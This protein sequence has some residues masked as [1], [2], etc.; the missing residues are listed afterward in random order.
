MRGPRKR[1]PG[2]RL[3]V[4]SLLVPAA[5]AVAPAALAT[6]KGQQVAG[7]AST[8][9]S[10]TLHSSPHD[11]FGRCMQVGATLSHVPAVGETADLDITLTATEPRDATVR[12]LLPAS[13]ALASPR[14]LTRAATPASDG[15]VASAFTTTRDLAAHSTQHLH[16]ALRGI[17]AGSGEIRVI[18]NAPMAGGLDGAA[19][20]VYLTVGTT[21]AASHAG[22]Q[23][24]AQLGVKHGPTTLAVPPLPGEHHAA[25]LPA[26]APGKGRSAAGVGPDATTC[27]V[28]SW[29]YYD[30]NG[31]WR[32]APNF[33]V[34][35]W[36]SNPLG[37][38]F[39]ANGITD[40][41][42]AYRICFDNHETGLFDSGTADVYLKFVS[43]VSQ[44]KINPVLTFST[45]VVQNV[46]AGDVNYGVLTAADSQYQRGLHA[47]D[48]VNDA[49]WALGRLPVYNQY[50]WDEIGDCVQKIINWTP[51]SSDG[52]YESGGQVHLKGDDPNAAITVNHEL[53]HAIMDDTYDG[54]YPPTNNCNP[55]YIQ[56]GTDTGCAWSEGW[57]TAWADFVY[58]DPSFRWPDGSYLDEEG[59]TWGTPGWGNGD[60]VEGRVTG[61]LWDISDSSQDSRYDRAAEGFGN[62]WYTFQHHTSANFASFWN[63]RAGD[64]FDVSNAYA[65]ASVYQNTIDYGFRDPL[66]NYASLTRDTPPLQSPIPGGSSNDHRYSFNTSTPYWSAVGL[67]TGGSD[68]DIYLYDDY[69]MGSLLGVSA[70][71]GSTIDF[72]TI[73]S[74][75]RAFGDYYPLVHDYAGSGSYQV[76][77]AQGSDQ[78]GSGAGGTSTVTMGSGDVLAVRDA[79]LNAGTQYTMRV[80]PSNAGQ[81]PELFAFEDNPSDGNTFVRSRSQASAS[82][83]SYGAGA[84][85]SLTFTPSYTEWHGI[86]VTNVSGSGTYGLYV[87]STPPTGS[88]AINGGAAYA[89]STAATLNLSAADA[90]TGLDAMRISTDGTFDSEPWV[91]YAATANVTLPSGD[92]VKTVWVQ[93]RNNAG[94]ISATASDDI[95]LDTVAP[96]LKKAPTVSLKAG[97]K[98][99]TS[100][101]PL[102]LAWKAATDAGSGLCSYDL[103]QSVNGGGYA[104]VALG[105]PIDTKVA[106]NA[107]P[108]AVYRFEIR[109]LDCAGN[110]SAYQV[111]STFVARVYDES[112]PSIGYAKAWTTAARANAWNGSTASSTVA[113]ATATLT[114]TGLQAAWVTPLSPTQG[115]ASVSLNGGAATTVDTVSKKKT[116]DRDLVYVANAAAGSNTLSVANQATAGRPRIDVDAFVVLSNS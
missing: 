81:N 33:Q 112:S 47:Y 94:L 79:Y 72:M 12:V 98:L 53:G 35:A 86:V 97:D 29:G 116:V 21:A 92:G 95:T 32:L 84:A 76:E 85:E 56:S 48:E 93:F 55:H 2:T 44:W 80:V 114:F 75:R 42:G 15:T 18:A 73:D 25:S 65:N 69:G 22:I 88:V 103:E 101:V 40:G 36:D 91:P 11:E 62:I 110:A 34:Q 113:N 1:P 43:E 58:N 16:V 82:A 20:Q 90:E 60:V 7:A 50:C 66:G 107:T 87:D 51:T 27:A 83:S 41:N 115:A 6:P 24:P 96:V 70:Y 52:T 89:H 23:A 54:Y 57:A 104:P 59:P 8:A 4:S 9:P 67:R 61:S 63:Q 5:L 102:E 26:Q 10:C 77:L 111:T 106:V 30:Q 64:G 49:F 39:L 46:P 105:T 3:L 100:T 45:G 19:D 99:G 14:A 38:T 71:G 109:A 108:G 31:A 13:L 74:N 28:G 68:Y 17:Q 37:D 78:A